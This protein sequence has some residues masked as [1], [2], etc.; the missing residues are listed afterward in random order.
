MYNY[1]KAGSRQCILWQKEYMSDVCIKIKNFDN[2]LNL[3]E[4]HT[5]L[6]DLFFSDTFTNLFDVSNLIDDIEIF[7]KNSGK[8]CETFQKKKMGSM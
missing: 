6:K 5:F 1:Q 8:S 2:C 3:C 7:V 4:N